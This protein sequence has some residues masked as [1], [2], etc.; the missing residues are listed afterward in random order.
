MFGKKKIMKTYDFADFPHLTDIKP[1]ERYVFHSDYYDIDDSVATILG[2]YHSENSDEPLPTFWGV[3]RLP[4][5]ILN[6][7]VTIIGFEQIARMS[8]SWVRDHKDTAEKVIGMN[9]N[10]QEE[11]GKSMSEKRKAK[12]NV[13]ELAEIMRELDNSASY[14]QC[15]YKMMVKAPDLDTLDDAVK[16]IETWYTERF[17]KSLLA[18]PLMGLQRQE[19][20]NLF[21]KNEKKDGRPFY[22]TSTEFAGSYSLVTHGI[23]DP[24]GE[25]VGYMKGD[26][27]NA[28]VL[29]EV[30]RYKEHVVVGSE[31]TKDRADTKIPVPDFW[32]SKISQSALMHNHRVVHIVLDKC[33]LDL[34]GPKFERITSK[35]DM[36]NGDVNMFEMFGDAKDELSIFARQEQKIRLMMNLISE[37]APEYKSAV[38][39][40]FH[41]VFTKF[42]IQKHMWDPDPSKN[43]HNLR[44]VGIPHYEV[45]RLNEFVAYIEGERQKYLKD[46][47]VERLHAA[48]EVM[49]T[50]RELSETNA[51]L[52]DKI[53]S[54]KIDY[55]RNGR[56]VIY[57]FSSLRVRGQEIAMAQLV[58]I[59]G[60]AV[61]NL[62]NGDVVIIHG[63][64]QISDKVKDYLDDQLKD[65]YTKG[66][67][68]VFL[69]NNIDKM[70]ADNDFSQTSKAD[71][72]IM[73]TMSPQQLA[74]YESVIG[75]KIPGDLKAQVAEKSPDMIYLR[76]GFTN[77]VFDQDLSLGMQKKRGLR[78]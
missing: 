61:G 49:S 53:T 19:L 50:F 62:S 67:R 27:N 29:F 69:Y 44:V 1:R 68:V 28:A 70:L 64:D 10:E 38:K 76:R 3:N 33:D 12:K 6:K 71:Y 51:D 5:N 60:Y 46:Q 45:P 34:L 42:Y 2:F 55:V 32:G 48:T 14:L 52:F 36:N 13:V 58:N 26:V 43:R 72:T 18:S 39:G 65:L 4:R 37:P 59:I 9:A 41:D 11:A 75:Q 78:I 25:Y 20:T 63:A 21:A 47:D 73:G 54:D 24:Y 23:E 7:N 8:E 15:V 30:D 16:S 57:D 31:W 66:G 77:V 35:I 17:G 56:R 22:Y 74:Q 40:V